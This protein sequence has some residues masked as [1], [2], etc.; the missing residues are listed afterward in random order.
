MSVSADFNT[1]LR[2]PAAVFWRYWSATTVS[3]VGSAITA[4]ALPVTAVSVLHASVL[5]M[6]LLTACGDLGWLVLTLPAGAI[7]SHVP[8]RGLQ[9]G[10][11]FIRGGAILIPPIAFVLGHLMMWQLFLAAAAISAA[12]VFAFV[13]NTTYIPSVVPRAQLASRNALMSGTEAVT[14]L[15]GPALAGALVQ[16]LTAPLTLVV[17]SVSY[18]VSGALMWTL[19]RASRSTDERQPMGLEIAEGWRF[20]TH[21]RL[22]RPLMLAA[23]TTNLVCGALMTLT[24]LYLIRVLHT[25]PA[26]YGL[27]LASEGMGALAGAAVATRLERRFGPA[28]TLIGTAAG[29]TLMLVV[30]PL[31]TGGAGQLIFAIT[32]AGF[33]FGTVVLSVLTRTYRQQQSPPEM[34]ARVMATVRFVSWSVIPLGALLA[35]FTAQVFDVRGALVLTALASAATALILLLSPL[36]RPGTILNEDSRV[37]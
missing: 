19:P 18:L 8:L 32:N 31:G 34:L 3:G 5:Q 11:D 28:V 15:G 23:T 21:H 17:D 13:T 6:G 25:P 20:V 2:Y 22:I 30:M 4:V 16:S 36:R 33:A 7:A 35:G 10:V 12:N 1:K 27:L 37:S 29:S 9:A 24:P 14:R 26:L